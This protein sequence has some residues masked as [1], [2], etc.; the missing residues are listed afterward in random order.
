MLSAFSEICAWYCSKSNYLLVN[1]NFFAFLHHRV[2]KK[3]NFSFSTG[4]WDRE[5]V[6][7]FLFLLGSL[8]VDV[9]SS[10]LC[11]GPKTNCALNQKLNKAIT[12]RLFSPFFSP[13]P[14]F[15]SSRHRVQ[16]GRGDGRYQRSRHQLQDPR[17]PP[18]LQRLEEQRED[19]L[20]RR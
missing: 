1:S 16:R 9:Y 13:Q 5:F 11:V 6:T 17:D 3:E 15:H 2:N 14:N 4:P 18:R 10:E 20:G 8:K 19:F 7:P 12:P